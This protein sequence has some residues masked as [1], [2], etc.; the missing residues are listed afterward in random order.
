[1]ADQPDEAVK[2][3]EPEKDERVFYRKFESVEHCTRAEFDK[4]RADIEALASK[5]EAV[6]KKYGHSL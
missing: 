4:L 2:T 3:P 1:M 5:F 6:C